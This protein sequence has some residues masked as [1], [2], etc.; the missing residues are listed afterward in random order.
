MKKILQAPLII[1]AIMVAL[2]GY[3][4]PLTRLTG[5]WIGTVTNSASK[6]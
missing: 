3:R 6:G 5:T 4:R 2:L 1:L